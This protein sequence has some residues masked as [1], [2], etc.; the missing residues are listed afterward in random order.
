MEQPGNLRQTSQILIP[1]K[2]T[3]PVF[4]LKFGVL[5]LKDLGDIDFYF[6]ILH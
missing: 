1:S 3:D 4:I 6:L 2:T 5:F